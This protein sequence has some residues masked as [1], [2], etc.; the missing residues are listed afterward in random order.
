M[1]ARQNLLQ[2]ITARIIVVFFHIS[3]LIFYQK[4]AF[5]IHF[6]WKPTRHRTGNDSERR[7]RLHVFTRRLNANSTGGAGNTITVTTQADAYTAVSNT[8]HS[9]QSIPAQ[10]G[11]GSET[12]SFT[13]A[14][15][16]ARRVPEQ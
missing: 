15:N 12:V 14:A 8:V 10:T 4:T 9:L 11:T 3:F 16:A 7:R 1:I 6:Y 5:F 2:G 13:V